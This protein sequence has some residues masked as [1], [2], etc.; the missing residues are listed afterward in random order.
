MNAFDLARV[1]PEKAVFRPALPTSS[2]PA[3]NGTDMGTMTYKEQLLHPN[4][5][6][7][8]L[9]VLSRADFHCECCRDD[10][11]TLHVHHKHYVKGRMAWE[12]DL[13]ELVALCKDCHAAEH[14]ISA[15]RSGLLA[16]LDAN[17]PFGIEDFVAYGAGA[18]ARYA[19]DAKAID[20][21]GHLQQEWALQFACGQVA[22][23]LNGLL[24]LSGLWGLLAALDVESHAT[25]SPATREL[26]EEVLLLFKKH[27]LLRQA[28]QNL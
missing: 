6:R 20:L 1:A 11:N 2:L 14:E 28:Y 26:Q 15:A 5:Q 21:L 3:L 23:R 4:W 22:E 25:A 10:S 16:R 8:R 24:S 12:Y 19:T 9:E 7:K 27:G 17:G 13:G 18:V